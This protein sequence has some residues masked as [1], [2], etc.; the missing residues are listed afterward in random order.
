ML[1]SIKA[2]LHQIPLDSSLSVA[3]TSNHDLVGSRPYCLKD[4][5]TKNAK[6]TLS[7]VTCIWGRM[8]GA[9][10]WPI[11][12][13]VHPQVWMGAW[14]ISHRSYNLIYFDLK[15]IVSVWSFPIESLNWK[16]YCCNLC[17][18]HWHSLTVA[19]AMLRRNTWKAIFK[20]CFY[21]FGVL[22]H[23]RWQ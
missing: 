7:W 18:R 22:L 14:F 8:K 11:W 9:V 10:N 15:C 5:C 4:M 2:L 1:C 12:G 23:G 13:Y 17:E 19:F 6:V 3:S 21:M 20:I 16:A